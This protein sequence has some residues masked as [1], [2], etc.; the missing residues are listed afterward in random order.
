MHSIMTKFTPADILR[1]LTHF[2]AAKK[3]E[4]QTF[5]SMASTFVGITLVEKKKKRKIII[6]KH[7]KVLY[8]VIDSIKMTEN[9]P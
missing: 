3:K 7:C 9:K 2:R 8:E 6:I 1:L 4:R 5:N